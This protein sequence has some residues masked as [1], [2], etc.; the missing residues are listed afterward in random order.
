MTTTILTSNTS[1]L[2]MVMASESWCNESK[3][4]FTRSPVVADKE[5]N[6]ARSLA[7]CSLQ[8]FDTD[9]GWQESK[10]SIQLFTKGSLPEK[11]KEKDLRGTG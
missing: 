10:N 1:I 5:K 11:M 3:T 8:C 4:T 2:T 6:G 9:N 7:L